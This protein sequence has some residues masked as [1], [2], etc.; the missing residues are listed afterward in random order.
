MTFRMH[1]VAAEHKATRI[2]ISILKAEAMTRKWWI[3][4]FRLDCSVKVKGLVKEF[5][6]LAQVF[7]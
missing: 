1:W 5:N 7:F 6:P 4:P 3:T 2:K